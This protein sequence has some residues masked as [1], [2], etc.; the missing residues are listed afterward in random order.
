MVCA[1]FRTENE[2]VTSGAAAMVA[3]PSWFAARTIFPDPVIVKTLFTIVAGP[4]LTERV[5]GSPEEAEGGVSFSGC[6]PTA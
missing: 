6:A 2:M 3:L 1:S 5:T 4:D